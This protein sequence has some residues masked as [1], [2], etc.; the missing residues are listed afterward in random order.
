MISWLLT[1][2]PIVISIKVRLVLT[3]RAYPVERLHVF[4]EVLDLINRIA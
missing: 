4:N 2:L 1:K 3:L